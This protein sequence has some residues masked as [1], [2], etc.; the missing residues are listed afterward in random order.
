MV[1]M[2][3]DLATHR[4]G[5]CVFNDNNLI[6]YA[7]IDANEKDDFRNR[8]RCIANEIDVIIK[9]YSPNKI[10]LEDAPIIKNSSASM[11]LIMQGYILSVIDKYN[12]LVKLFQPSEWRKEIGII[13]KNGRAA[14]KTDEIK[15]R[16]IDYVN[17]RFDLNFFYKKDS[18]KSDDNIADAIGVACCGMLRCLSVK[19]DV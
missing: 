13:G 10:F 14:L 1:Y 7:N 3:L 9:K 17:K 2:G 5:C 16:T 11:L 4:T 15:Q 12:I 19:R 8:I 18:I 6:Y